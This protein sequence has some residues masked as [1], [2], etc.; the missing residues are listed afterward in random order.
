[1]DQADSR[2]KR[3]LDILEADHVELSGHLDALV[4]D[5]NSVLAS[6]EAEGPELFAK[7]GKL[8]NTLDEITD[9]LD[10]HLAD[11]EDL[12]VPILLHHGLNLH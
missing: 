3:G 2:F 11:E 4:G 1:M 12:I 6:V 10:R 8:L 5:A 7:A 9:F